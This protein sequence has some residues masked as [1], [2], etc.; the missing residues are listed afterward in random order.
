[1]SFMRITRIVER[2]EL[3][4]GGCVAPVVLKRACEGWSVAAA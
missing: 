4:K 1:M 3:G 2:L